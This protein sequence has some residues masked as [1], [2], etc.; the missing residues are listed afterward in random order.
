MITTAEVLQKTIALVF[1]NAVEQPTYVAMYGDLC[2]S[3]SKEL[4]H[5]PP[6]PGS[7]KP[8]SFRQILL[9]TCQ[10]E[11]EAAADAREVRAKQCMLACEQTVRILHHRSL[12][13]ALVR[14]LCGVQWL[15][16][17]FCAACTREKPGVHGVGEAGIGM[18]MGQ[19]DGL[20]GLI[21]QRGRVPYAMRPSGVWCLVYRVWRK[22]ACLEAAAAA[23]SGS[24]WIRSGMGA[25]RGALGGRELVRLQQRAA[26]AGAGVGAAG[27]RRPEPG[28]LI[29][30]QYNGCRQGDGGCSGFVAAAAATGRSYFGEPVTV[31]RTVQLRREQGS[32]CFPPAPCNVYNGRRQGMPRQPYRTAAAGRPRASAQLRLGKRDRLQ[33]LLGF[34]KVHAR[35]WPRARPQRAGMA[36]ARSHKLC[37]TKSLSSTTHPFHQRLPFCSPHTIKPRAIRIHAL[38]RTCPPSRSL[39]S[40][41][42][43]SAP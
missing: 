30:D 32:C 6:P 10:D 2:V 35:A 14:S 39:P 4:P 25:R 15:A 9:N 16:L 38:C 21:R 11:F 29:L 13:Y 20:A 36:S 26:G 3:L 37:R 28:G 23:G 40:A 12:A 42:R 7:D 18:V 31:L 41:R 43:L 34:A 27:V 5:F 8:L 33:A 19:E 22:R 24:G 1:E 17:G